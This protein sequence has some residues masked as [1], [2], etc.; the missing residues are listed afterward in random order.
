MLCGVGLA[1]PFLQLFSSPEPPVHLSRPSHEGRLWGRE[2]S[3]GSPANRKYCKTFLVEICSG[4]CDSQRWQDIGQVRIFGCLCTETK[5]RCTNKHAKTKTKAKNKRKRM[6]PLHAREAT[7]CIQTYLTRQ[8]WS[9]KDR[10]IVTGRTQRVIP[11][12]LVHLVP[13][14]SYPCCNIQASLMYFMWLL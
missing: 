12:S 6:R 4:E 14:R 2:C 1:L 9:R 10:K 13:V 11:P 8:A 7:T 5:S 3:S